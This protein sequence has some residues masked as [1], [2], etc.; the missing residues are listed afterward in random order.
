[1]TTRFF[2]THDKEDHSFY[3]LDVVY[4]CRQL[5]V[6]KI[7]DKESDLLDTLRDKVN[8]FYFHHSHEPKQVDSIV[9]GSLGYVAIHFIEG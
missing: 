3:S 1:M 7:D 2:E 5:A 8:L 9:F 4:C 6:F